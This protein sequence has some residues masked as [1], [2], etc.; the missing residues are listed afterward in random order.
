MH[1][2]QISISTERILVGKSISAEFAEEL[3]TTIENIFL[4]SGE[5][6]VVVSGA[7]LRG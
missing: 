7:G 1:G 5:A 4:S 6:L 3:K 2:G